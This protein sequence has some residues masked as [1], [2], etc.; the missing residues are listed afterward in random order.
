MKRRWSGSML[1]VAM[2]A[3]IAIFPE[4]ARAGSKSP[5]E[6]APKAAALP[7]QTRAQDPFERALEAVG[8]TRSTMRFDYADMSNYGGDEFSLPLF[9]T[10]HSNPFKTFDYVPVFRKAVE[11]NS[12]T[13][14]NLVKF[15]SLRLGQGVR[16]G[17]FTN[18]LEEIDK[19]LAVDSLS[20]SDP[21][22]VEKKARESLL[23]RSLKSTLKL[24]RSS[25]AEIEGTSRGR[26][27]SFPHR[28][29]GPA[30]SCFFPPWSH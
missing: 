19:K 13:L 26:S 9:T 30:H 27:R 15:C 28:C 22:K 2:V 8:L 24:A 5:G 4:G 14:L 18:P 1:G 12:D 6:T 7:A 11:A 20:R 23:P 17:D 3:C 10:L 25:P 29:A 16:R 21:V